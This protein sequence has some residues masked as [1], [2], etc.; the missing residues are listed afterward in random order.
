MI[1]IF[2][3]LSLIDDASCLMVKYQVGFFHLLYPHPCLWMN[4]NKYIL[5]L[6]HKPHAIWTNTSSNFEKYQVAFLLLLGLYPCLWILPHSL[7]IC[8]KQVWHHFDEDDED[9]DGDD[10]EHDDNDHNV[11][12]FDD[13]ILYLKGSFGDRSSQPDFKG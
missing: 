7:P 8:Q 4:L 12:F 1:I 6:E 9:D 11:Y 3:V 5:P 10:D 2:V 13:I